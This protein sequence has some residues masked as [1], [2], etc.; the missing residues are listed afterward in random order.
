MLP[1]IIPLLIGHFSAC[2]RCT[3][4]LGERGCLGSD[5]HPCCLE[6]L[7]AHNLR[8]TILQQISLF[9]LRKNILS[10]SLLPLPFWPNPSFFVLPMQI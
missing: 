6:I 9:S 1:F 4:E 10:N 2:V 5:L 7:E 3:Y 8:N